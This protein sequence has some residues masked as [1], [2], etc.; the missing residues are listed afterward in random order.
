MS[1]KNR[2]WGWYTLGG[3]RL[4]ENLT[5]ADKRYYEKDLREGKKDLNWLEISEMRHWE[6][7]A[8]KKDKIDAMVREGRSDEL[9]KVVESF[10][11]S[12]KIKIEMLDD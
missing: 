3:F 11:G 10:A 7:E 6:R 8:K 9:G 12:G 4:D 5:K 1:R 2:T